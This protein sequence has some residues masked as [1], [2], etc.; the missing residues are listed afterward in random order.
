[1]CTCVPKKVPTLA[2][3]SCKFHGQI[4]IIFGIKRDNSFRNHMYVPLLLS[5]QQQKYHNSY[6]APYSVNIELN[7]VKYNFD[8]QERTFITL[9]IMNLYTSKNNMCIKIVIC[10]TFYL[11]YLL[12]TRDL[13]IVFFRSNRILNRIGRP[14][15]F[16]IES[17][18]RISRIYHASRNTA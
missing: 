4:L 1:M 7:L 8:T 2:H 16:R 15:R 3:C 5:L 10:S 9:G 11:L 18:N 12:L 17:S 6:F 14:I 13:R